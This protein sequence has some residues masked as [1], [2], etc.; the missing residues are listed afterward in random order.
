MKTVRINC[1]KPFLPQDGTVTHKSTSYRVSK[2]LDFNN[3]KNI[4]L[5][6]LNDTKNLYRLEAEIDVPEEQVLYCMV[7]F[8]F[9]FVTP[10]GI[11]DIESDWSS[12][13]TISDKNN[14]ITL[15][16]SIIET[17]TVDI[18]IEEKDITITSNEFKMWNG[19]G[20]HKSS[21]FLIKDTDN[22]IVESRLDD[23]DNLTNIVLDNTLKEGR[24]Y[25]GGVKHN[26]EGNGVG[27]YGI[28]FINNSNYEQSLFEFEAP[29]KFVLNRKFYYRIKLYISKFKS[30]DLEIRDKENNVLLSL[31]NQ[32][33]LVKYF[34][35]S[36]VFKPMGIYYLY[37][38]LNLTDGRSTDFKF[39]K[40]LECLNNTVTPYIPSTYYSN[41][42]RNYGPYLT[43]GIAC[44]TTRELYDGNIIIPDNNTSS[45]SLYKKNGY[46][47]SMLKTILTFEKMTTVKYINIL[48]LPNRDILIDILLFS[49]DRQYITKFILLDYDPIKYEFKVLG[50]L[51]RPDERY[52]TSVTNSLV[53]TKQSRVLY[54]PNYLTNKKSEDPQNLK[55]REL[56]LN[57]DEELNFKNFE[58]IEKDLPL[59]IK[60][61]PGLMIDRYD[62]IYFF[63]GSFTNRYDKKKNEE[64]WL[65]DNRDVYKISDTLQFEKVAR[66]PDEIPKEVYAF[67]PFLR[68]DGEIVLF[69]AVHSGTGL[70]YNKFTNFNP[71]T[72]EFVIYDVNGTIDVPIRNN[73]LFRS[74]D[75]YRITSKEK[76]PQQILTYN[77]NL[78]ANGDISV[79]D[80]TLDLVVN[81]GEVIFTEDVYKYNS[82]N[83]NGTGVLR[84]VR[85]QGIT[86]ITSST[87]IVTKNT[88]ILESDFKKSKYDTVLILDGVNLKIVNG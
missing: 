75:I 63:G 66:I 29:E 26:T 43:N 12:I 5:E 80:N 27:N 62:N 25:V 13:I 20:I 54:I 42:Y 7:K 34:K 3:P 1:Y 30:Y 51:E 58:L 52:N 71:V 84:W 87:Y 76:D 48:Q 79:E 18:K 55:L 46:N 10:V 19:V 9:S 86:D 41:T 22:S 37:I 50:E 56:K 31:T 11:K 28:G 53:V 74:G 83:I 61:N 49:K 17:P 85:P 67:Q 15:S 47:I 44:M 38:R 78:V 8:T 39:I 64:Y 70:N 23:E 65:L 73:L 45:I 72:N 69:N 16:D 40:E 6:N 88:N 60:F 36:D 32:N 14:E 4:V 21:S 24:I 2:G 57:Y 35:V 82:I 81:D 68:L 33:Q 77:T 59:S